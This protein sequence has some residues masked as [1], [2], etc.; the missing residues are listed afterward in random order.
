MKLA[1]KYLEWAEK[2]HRGVPHVV[3]LRV[4][5]LYMKGEVDKAAILGAE[6]L[7]RHSYPALRYLT[8]VACVS[9]SPNRVPDR[10]KALGILE[11]LLNDS[12]DTSK[13][14]LVG[15]ALAVAILHDLNRDTESWQYLSIFNRVFNSL[16]V[17]ERRMYKKI[18]VLANKGTS[19]Q[20][21][22]DE[23]LKL[24]VTIIDAGFF[25]D[26]NAAGETLAIE[27]H[28]AS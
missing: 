26:A 17:Q 27:H 14:R 16:S 3:T 13:W 5:H 11:P 12:A 28:L 2:L 25:D 23:F 6:S 21:L 20:S 9:A 8:A 22:S 15:L 24:N 10:K 19:D 4:Y 18:H 7:K 1:E